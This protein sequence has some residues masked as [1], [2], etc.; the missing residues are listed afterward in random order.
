MECGGVP[1]TGRVGEG[2]LGLLPQAVAR[3]H[4]TDLVDNAGRDQPGGGD[5]WQQRLAAAGRNRGENV[6]RARLTERDRLHDATQLLLMRAERT[7]CQANTRAMRD[8][9]RQSS[10]ASGSVS[11]E[12]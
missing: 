10:T 8:V 1:A 9:I 3:H 2:F 7:V 6:A 11:L 5:H 12:H 4:P